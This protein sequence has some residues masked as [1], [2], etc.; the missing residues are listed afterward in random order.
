MKT[1]TCATIR[2]FQLYEIKIGKEQ[3]T[4]YHNHLSFFHIH[5]FKDTKIEKITNKK[6]QT[7]KKNNQ[8]NKKKQKKTK[9]RAIESKSIYKIFHNLRC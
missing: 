5:F 6:E 3:R 8:S 1:K 7:N 4:V 2:T 9:K